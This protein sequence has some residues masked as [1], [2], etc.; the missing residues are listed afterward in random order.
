MLLVRT[1]G[2]SEISIGHRLIG[3]EHPTMFMLLLLAAL[4]APRPLARAELAMLL[5][6]DAP[7]GLR[8]HRLRS[9]L[10]RVR[11]ADVL[12][13]CSETTVRLVERAQFDFR[14][15]STLPR[16][17][18]DVQRHVASIGPILPGLDGLDSSALSARVDDERDVIIATVI[19]WVQAALG[20]AKA[21]GDWPLVERLARAGREVDRFNEEAWLSL[22]EAQCLT[23]S[24]ARALRTLDEYV[25]G[26]GDRS[27]AIALPVELLRQRVGEAARSVEAPVRVVGGTNCAPVRVVVFQPPSE[28]VA[29][30][31]RLVIALIARLLAERGA[32]GCD[33]G[34]YDLLRR[35]VAA[36]SPNGSDHVAQTQDALLPA[37]MELLAAVCEESTLILVIERA[38]VIRVTDH[39]FWSRVFESSAKLG[40]V[41]IFVHE[42]RV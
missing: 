10:H 1:L 38:Q 33:P 42:N 34:A 17:L 22:A 21:A 16:T 18:D 8:S 23:A 41:W 36:P 6:S 28:C 3:P 14:D 25:T 13:E 19:R 37:F 5:W 29:C 35:A 40:L 26:I 4:R 30:T 9:L 31:D 15:F 2:I 39:P 27:D 12:M 32:A 11:Q 20:I 7:S 24:K